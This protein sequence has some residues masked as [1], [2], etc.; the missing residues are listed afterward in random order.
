VEN[1]RPD[2]DDE[3]DGAVKWRLI[4]EE[5]DII[6]AVFNAFRSEGG[7]DEMWVYTSTSPP[8]REEEEAEET[9]SRGNEPTFRPT[10]CR[11]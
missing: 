9:Q 11:A 8:I 2:E 1:D 10:A 3:Y 4:G 5:G 6:A 7:W